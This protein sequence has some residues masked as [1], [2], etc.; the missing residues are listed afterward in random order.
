M[1]AFLLLIGL[2][3]TTAPAFSAEP[4]SEEDK[5]YDSR[6][7]ASDSEDVTEFGNT[8]RTQPGLRECVL[9]SDCTLIEGV[10]EASEAVNVQR[11]Q[12]KQEANRKA[13][14]VAECT[15]SQDRTFVP[16]MASCVQDE[17]VV[18]KKRR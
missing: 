14:A 1:R 4:P 9:D 12:A 11:A 2:L 3:L 8:I 7:S 13:R 6:E 16:V 10:C 15:I 18:Q 17:C 5:F